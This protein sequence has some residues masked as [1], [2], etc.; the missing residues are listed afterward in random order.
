LIAV[1]TNLLVYAHR[2]DSPWHMAASECLRSLAEG[3]GTWAILW[4]CIHEFYSIATH[5][6]IYN[7][8]STPAQAADQIDAW[9]ESPTVEL[10]GE[11]ANH[12]S[13]LRES[14]LSG[15]V[16][17][18]VVQDARIATL[19]MTHGV[20]ELLTADRDFSRFPKLKARNPLV[21]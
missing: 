2:A 18:P 19:C 20:R 7:P 9:L 15:R 17:G 6:R 1:D 14:L 5:P 10:L 21:E 13:V 11:A 16:A 3:P 4:P 8:P 12:W